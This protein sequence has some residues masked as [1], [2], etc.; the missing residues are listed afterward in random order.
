[1]GYYCYFIEAFMKLIL[2]PI[3]KCNLFKLQYQPNRMNRIVSNLEKRPW[4]LAKTRNLK[5]I[6]NFENP[7]KRQE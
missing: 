1:M 3:P 5:V 2:D 4:L 7:I 6:L